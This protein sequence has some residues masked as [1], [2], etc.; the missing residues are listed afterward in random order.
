MQAG[1]TDMILL[2]LDWSPVTSQLPSQADCNYSFLLNIYLDTYY[3]VGKLPEQHFSAWLF[4]N[5]GDN[6]LF[7]LKL[8][9]GRMLVVEFP[10]N[11]TRQVSP[12]G[13]RSY[14]MELN[15]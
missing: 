11:E 7:L 14:P 1:A 3:N 6:I 5:P 12:N 10:G 13:S 15:H 4:S 2:E 8:N 9:E